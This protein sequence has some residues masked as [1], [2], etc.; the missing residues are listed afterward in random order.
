MTAARPNTTASFTV[1]LPDPGKGALGGVP[2]PNW[3][4][5]VDDPEQTSLEAIHEMCKKIRELQETHKQFLIT[6]IQSVQSFADEQGMSLSST[7]KQAR[8]QRVINGP[9]ADGAFPSPSTS[10]FEEIAHYRAVPPNPNGEGIYFN[11]QTGY[12]QVYL[13]PSRKEITI[14]RFK[15]PT[16]PDTQGIQGVSEEISGNEQLRYWSLCAQDATA[17]LATTGCLYDAQVV[18]DGDDY[19]TVA[20]SDPESRPSNAINWLPASGDIP[21]LILRHMQPNPIFTEALLYY[22]GDRTDA[23]AISAHMGEYFPRVTI[24]TKAEFER[25]RCGLTAPTN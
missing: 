3:Y 21:G 9:S 14:V 16:F 15:A 23:A 18:P 12:L 22:D 2:R 20:F 8:D 13:G 11:A 6:S 7:K 10:D 19:V 25:D 17:A 24:C 4:F 1:F 5:V